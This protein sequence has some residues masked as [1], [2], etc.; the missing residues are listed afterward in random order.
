MLKLRYIKHILNK[1]TYFQEFDFFIISEFDFCFNLRVEG[2]ILST[3]PPKHFQRCLR[4]AAKKVPPLVVRPLMHYPP[5][6]LE[7]SG[8]RNFFFSF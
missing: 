6:P 5:R 7:L 2:L 8:H 1:Y 3:F 4:E